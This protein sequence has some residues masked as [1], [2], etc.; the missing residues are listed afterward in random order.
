MLGG[1]VDVCTVGMLGV[2]VVIGVASLIADGYV[3]LWRERRDYEEY[4]QAHEENARLGRQL[5]R[6]RDMCEWEA[7][8][9]DA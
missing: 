5:R 1:K 2:S 4:V 7:K 9:H 8:Q 3:G 6:M